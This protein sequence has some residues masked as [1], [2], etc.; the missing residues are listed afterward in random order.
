MTIREFFDSGFIV[1]GEVVVKEYNPVIGT[2][3]VLGFKGYGI[4][5]EVKDRKITYIYS[6]NDMLNIEVEKGS[7]K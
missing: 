2:L 3:V 5:E 4:R 6:K 1:D 7:K